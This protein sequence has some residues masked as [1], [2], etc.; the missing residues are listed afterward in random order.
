M[1]KKSV[2]LG[3]LVIILLGF[4]AYIFAFRG[5]A[6]IAALDEN[7]NGIWDDYENVVAEKYEN[8]PNVK[9]AALQTGK[10]LQAL[11]SP[12]DI[13]EKDKVFAKAMSCLV[14]SG[15]QDGLSLSQATGLIEEMRDI[16]VNNDIRQAEYIKY[17]VAVSGKMLPV[18]I[19]N[20]KN[21]DFEITGGN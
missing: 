13:M 19:P 2:M 10:S 5:E 4:A 18:E 16:V 3:T 12:S 8:L 17:N 9:K 11:L 14:F 1:K 6:D 7:G 15:L 21:C 20:K